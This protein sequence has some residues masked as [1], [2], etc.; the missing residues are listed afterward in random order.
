MARERR[1]SA[2]PAQLGLTEERLLLSNPTRRIDVHRV[3]SPKGAFLR[4]E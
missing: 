1:D 4:K 2:S 3:E